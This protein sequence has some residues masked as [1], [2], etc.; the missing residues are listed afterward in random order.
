MNPN[1]IIPS[2][3][4]GHTNILSPDVFNCLLNLG[5]Q[6]SSAQE[7]S[8]FQE[9]LVLIEVYMLLAEP[10][11]AQGQNKQGQVIS[12]TNCS[13]CPHKFMQTDKETVLTPRKFHQ[14]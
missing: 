11:W 12:E 4:W 13:T 1:K 14:K 9:P 5:K 3:K 8:P 6:K 2:L 7:I 10:S